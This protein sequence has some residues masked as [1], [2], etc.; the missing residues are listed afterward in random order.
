MFVLVLV[1]VVFFA[2]GFTSLT[3]TTP[4]LVSVTASTPFAV[5]AA[6]GARAYPA[7]PS[8]IRSAAPN[9]ASLAIFGSAGHARGTI[10]AKPG[11]AHACHTGSHT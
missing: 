8:S 10:A 7:S 1:L 4:P 2:G 5:T 11:T 3:A 9:A 6:A